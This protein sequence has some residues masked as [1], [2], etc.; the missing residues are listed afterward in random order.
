MKKLALTLAFGLGILLAGC[1]QSTTATPP[2]AATPSAAS[3]GLRGQLYE[4]S[5]KGIGQML[6]ASALFIGNGVS[7]QAL[8]NVPDAAVT[9]QPIGS[10]T[11][12][13]NGSR[14]IRAI[15]KVTNKTTQT[16]EHLTFVP[17]NTDPDNDPA[18]PILTTPTVGN[19]YFKSLLTYGATDASAR[20]TALSA[21][22]GKL[23]SASQGT[24]V[25]D[26]D[27]TP[28]TAVDTSRLLPT[29]P[30]GLV[31]NGVSS[32][33]WRMP[34][35]LLPGASANV[36]FAVDMALDTPT[37]DPFE[38]SVVLTLADDPSVSQV[39]FVYV[40]PSDR[41]FRAD[42][43]SAIKTA[44][45]NVQS[46]YASQLSGKTFSIEGGAVT[47]CTLPQ[48]A[49]FYAV[50]SWSKVTSD[51]QSCQPVT[52]G[53]AITT[54]VL[55]ADVNHSCNA[56]G[57]LGASLPGLTILPAQ[58]ILGVSGLPVVNECGDAN[59]APLNRWYGGLGHEM[60]H[61]FGLP[62]PPTCDATGG[63]PTCDT[64]ALMWAGY[65]DYPNTYFRSD[66]KTILYGSPFIK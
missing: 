6:S 14:H 11:F 43:L 25:T 1:G 49:S 4:V 33:G 18:T 38:F 50:D 20:A 53:S 62:H 61:A 24:A 41:P 34:A 59:T 21:T 63:G 44:A 47:T 54:W 42:S 60:G 22:T 8:K 3:S 58:D 15:F 5:F 66:E 30:A 19:T 64:K 7:Q 51:I 57:R 39:R 2:S 40:R 35:G 31:I 29:A 48:P 10:D 16:I 65:A 46:W 27:A 26:P 37:T 23:L 17:V 52:S 13:V 56:A 9:L 45:L 36:T 32:Q 28:Y 55:Y 12:K